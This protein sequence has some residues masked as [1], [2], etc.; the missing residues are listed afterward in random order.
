MH[1][2]LL[3]IIEIFQE[4]KRRVK[5]Y[6]P[7]PGLR[8]RIR[9]DPGFFHLLDP[10]PDPGVAKMINFVTIIEDYLEV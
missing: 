3:C 2:E 9:V 6:Q 5:T 8:I 10:D 1:H 4:K 7:R